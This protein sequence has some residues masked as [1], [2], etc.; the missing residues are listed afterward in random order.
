MGDCYSADHIAED[1]IHT[2][3]TYKIE[4][5]QQMYRLGTVSN[6]LLGGLK[7]VL[8]DPN[9]DPKLL[10]WFKTFG[11]HEIVAGDVYDGVF[12]CC[13]FSHEMSWMRSWT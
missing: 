7:H 1:H 5:P 4:E 3:I 6:R 11:P 9:P 13:P 8:L 12:L 2:D 10:Q